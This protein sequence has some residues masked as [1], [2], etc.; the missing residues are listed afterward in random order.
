MVVGVIA[1]LASIAS[2]GQVTV[3]ILQLGLLA[4]SCVIGSVVPHLVARQLLKGM[5]E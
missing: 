1:P 3:G 5:Q 4:L 2:S